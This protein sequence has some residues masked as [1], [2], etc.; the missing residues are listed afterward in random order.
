MTGGGV[1]SL[2]LFPMNNELS[3]LPL[4]GNA[5]S[6]NNRVGGREPIHFAGPE[7]RARVCAQLGEEPNL[8]YPSYPSNT[9]HAF[10]PPNPK[11]FDST[12]RTGCRRASLGT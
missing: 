4:C 11:L 6:S 3:A 9:R 10:C 1:R 2:P 5:D 8:N 7:E 12:F